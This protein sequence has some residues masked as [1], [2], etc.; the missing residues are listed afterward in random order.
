MTAHKLASGGHATV[1]LTR[2]PSGELVARKEPHPHLVDDPDV[3]RA[4][5][6]EV[7]IAMR[8]Q[9]ENVVRLRGLET[10]TGRDAGGAAGAPGA[11]AAPGA[12]LPVL[13]LDYVEGATVAELIRDWA[14]DTP[15]RATVAAVVRIVL[16]AAAGLAALHALTDERGQPLA[17]VHRDVSPQNVLVGRDGVARVSDFGLAKCLVTDRATTEGI[18][19]G[20]AGYLAPEYV[21]G[22]GGDHRQDV[23]SLGVV[24]W[25]AL[26]R[27]RLF[28][29]ESDVQTLDRVLTMPIPSLA[30]KVPALAAVAAALDPVLARALAREPSE[31]YAS[32]SAF[33]D[34]LREAAARASVL[35]T[36][37]DVTASFLPERLA[38]L[39]E[40]RRA[41]LAADAPV[42][43]AL[44]ATA[45]APAPRRGVVVAGAIAIVASVVLVG[46]ALR[47]VP[48]DEGRA[49][50]LAARPAPPPSVVA[51][52]APSTSTATSS[53]S[54]PEA[55]VAAPL[56]SAS[57]AAPASAPSVEPARRASGDAKHPAIRPFTAGSASAAKPRPNPY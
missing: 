41:V 25:E 39:D 8:L 51:A 5:R 22:Q 2:S 48:A 45:R 7:E 11:S 24:A 53:A 16:D 44:D 49:S 47:R 14:K 10:L 38:M 4:L 21:R 18:L 1:W 9:H 23:F 19:K 26:T 46:V 6:R 50:D 28:R 42:A 13:L 32:A 43:T 15:A 36:A 56:A 30:E 27:T 12:A 3:L 52:I 35:G 33:A 40:R 17:L 57:S 29:G 54:A 37:A 20:K 55:P 34:A 31:R